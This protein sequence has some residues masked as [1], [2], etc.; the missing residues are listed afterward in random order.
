M[1]SALVVAYAE[2][3][4]AFFSDML[5]AAFCA[6]IVAVKT[7]SAARRMLRERNFELVIINAPLRDETGEGL[8][9]HAA[10]YSCQVILVVKG[11]HYEAIAAATENDGILTVAKP[12]NRAIFWPVLKL[13]TAAQHRI[14]RL[15]AENTKLTQKV[16]D[17]R[18]IDRAKCILISRMKMSEQ[19]AHR[20]IEKQAM[21]MR[22]SRRNIAERILK[23]YDS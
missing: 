6:Q 16:E 20:Y 17:I 8:A 13:A 18:I 14:Q 5:S 1:D 21:D 12:L 4:I 10:Q 22:V 11:E 19:E 23:T 15:Q 7:C 2:N 9:L 3:S